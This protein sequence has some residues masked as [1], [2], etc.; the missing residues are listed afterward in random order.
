[1]K[2]AVC[3]ATWN[4]G[5]G[6][7]NTAYS[8]ARQVTTF[9]VEVCVVDDCSD[10]NPEP[11]LR[12]FLPDLRYQR[13][14]KRLGFNLAKNRCLDLLPPDVGI[15]V[16]MNCDVVLVQDYLLEDLCRTVRRGVVVFCEVLDLPAPVDLHDDFEAGVEA[17]TAGWE[18]QVAVQ[19]VSCTGRVIPWA[20][21]FFLG[22]I[23]RDDLERLDY[24]TLSCDAVLA[25]RMKDL[26][27]AD[28][29]AYLRGVHQRHPKEV[30][31]CPVQETCA[32]WCARTAERDG[33]ERPANYFSPARVIATRQ[34][35]VCL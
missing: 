30:F 8:L 29:L 24:R 9:P 7:R 34:E 25:P 5:E 21:L 12:E 10:N 1:M 31:P 6:L 15:V 19:G 35:N 2:V 28:L 22:A 13:L 27:D 32:Q 4:K 11:F 23:R 17:V 26:F 14:P 33:V 20:W 3:M 18:S 16:L